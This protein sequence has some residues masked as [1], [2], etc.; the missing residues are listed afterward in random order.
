MLKAFAEYL[1][2]LK[3]NKTYTFH[4][5]DIYSDRELHRIA[6]YMPR[7]ERITVNG[8]DSIV[9][10]V[11]NE[12]ERID[13][14]ALPLFVRVA[15]PREVQVYSGLDRDMK[16]Y[17]LYRAICDAPEFKGGWRDYDTA[18]IQLRS[19]FAQNG[20]TEYLLDLLSRISK[21]DGV[22]T[23]D[24]GVTQTVEARQGISL[25]VKESI[26]PRVALAPF[27]TFSEVVQPVSDF[28]TRVD[29]EGNI[30]FFEADGGAWALA[31]KHN[32]EEYLLRDDVGL[33]DLAET[34]KVVVMA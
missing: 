34:G 5:G 29:G 8:L 27:R 20:G 2:S 22:T 7:P 13:E 21:E 6:P 12:F 1:V 24:N 10:L 18:I 31:A 9:Q 28:L 30:G 15:S 32:I 33:A 11:R 19:M 14:E 26:K 16:R 23:T 25:K 17:E 4:G 3:D